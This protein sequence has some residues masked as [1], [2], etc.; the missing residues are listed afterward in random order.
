MKPIPTQT[1][2]IFFDII[3]NNADLKD[4]HIAA[5]LGCG[6]SL[7]FLYQLSKNVGKKGLIYAVDILESALKAIEKEVKHHS[8]SG[9]SPLRANLDNKGGT[10]LPDKSLNRAFLINT[11]HQS[12]DSLTMLKEAHRLL[13][14]EGRLLLVDWEDIDHPLGP[15]KN[16]RISKRDAEDIVTLAGFKPIKAFKAGP[17]HYGFVLIKK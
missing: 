15:H 1:S 7:V 10:P 5:D 3:I 12:S 9:I 6:S 2:L 16:R 14:N 13:D 11:L 17:H 8:L 4:G